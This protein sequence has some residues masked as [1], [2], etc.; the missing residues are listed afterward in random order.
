MA[1][2][3]FAIAGA[4]G[5]AVGFTGN[6]ICIRV[7][8]AGGN[9]SDTEKSTEKTD[10]AVATLLTPDRAIRRGGGTNGIII[11]RAGG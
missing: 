10:G 1:S 5:T 3:G 11:L 9:K 4:V 8:P 6:P 2:A 7:D